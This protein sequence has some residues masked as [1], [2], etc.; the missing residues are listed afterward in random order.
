MKFM[1]YI[2]NRMIAEVSGMDFA[3]EVYAKASELA[4]M[5]G[6]IANLVNG[7]TGEVI[8]SSDDWDDYDED[9]KPDYDEY[10]F[11]PFVKYYTSDC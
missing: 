11:G 5:I 4:E 2:E 7:E 1:I 3:Y 8:A 6:E 9:Y 10:G